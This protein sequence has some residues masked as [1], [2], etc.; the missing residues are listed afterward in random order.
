MLQSNGYIQDK[1]ESL[2]SQI[3]RKEY[4]FEKKMEMRKLKT[5]I[6]SYTL[7]IIP[8][9]YISWKAKYYGVNIA[10]IFLVWQTQS[11]FGSVMESIFNELKAVHYSVPYIDE[12]CDFLADTSFED[13]NKASE[14]KDEGTVLKHVDFSYD[15][16]HN[17]LEDI[18]LKITPGEK[19]AIIGAN[20]AGKTTLVKLI[21]GLYNATNG[22]ID[23][24]FSTHELG[25]VWQ[26]YVKFE[27]TLRESVG[28]GYTDHMQKDE[29][30]VSLL[31][32]LDLEIPGED[33]LEHMMGR[34]FD[35][36]GLI[37]SEGQWQKIAIARAVFGDRIFLCMDEPTAALD[38]IS[39]VQLY[40]EI[41]K[42]YADQTVVFVSH[43]VGFASLADRIIVVGDGKIEEDG[44]HE[45]LIQKKGYYY[46]FYQEQLRWY[47]R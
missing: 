27:L 10:A 16:I 8:L 37:P 44:T 19:V 38:P 30:I 9:V 24:E 14:K 20:G 12:L 29:K 18:N 35:P 26:D 43:R 34:A 28:L 2:D 17:V 47:E 6:L 45:E 13:E 32:D 41:K 42:R 1:W 21:A 40:S 3:Y 36:D 39:E 7:K 5:N 31:K 4:Q 23:R 33:A 25:V 22:Q 11:Q 15:D 46:Q